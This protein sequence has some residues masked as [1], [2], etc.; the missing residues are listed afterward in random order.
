MGRQREHEKNNAAR[1][2]TKD[3]KRA[4]IEK[5]LKEDTSLKV[6]VAVFRVNDLTDGQK[7]YKV[8]INAEQLYLTGCAVMTNQSLNV[9]VVEGG[10]QGIKKYKKL[11]LSR[12]KWSGLV[13]EGDDSD[14]DDSKPKNKCKLVWEGQVTERAFSKFDMKVCRTEAFAREQL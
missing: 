6:E 10:A 4:K 1:A 2:L 14:D 9:V 5:K 13:D 7:K 3:Q 12:I 11:M 8:S